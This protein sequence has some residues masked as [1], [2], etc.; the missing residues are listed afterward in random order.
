[1][2]RQEE[3]ARDFG[4]GRPSPLN[5]YAPPSGGM[6]G[7]LDWVIQCANEIYPI[8]GILFVG[9]KLQLLALLTFLEEECRINA[10]VTNSSRGTKGK[11]EVKNLE[12]SVN[13]DARGV[14]SSR[15]N[16]KGRGFVVIL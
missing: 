14:R 16:R 4:I 1:L 9:H 13:S 5:T 12:C 8:V 11:K 6:P 10:M 2:S 3:G 15:G 7:Y